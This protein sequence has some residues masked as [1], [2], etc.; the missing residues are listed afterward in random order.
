[1]E[2][3][4]KI[5]KWNLNFKS[6]PQPKKP[7]NKTKTKNK[8]QSREWKK[9]FE[10]DVTIKGLISK[11]IKN[12]S[13]SSLS[14]KKNKKKSNNPIQ[15]WAEDLNRHLSKGEIQMTN[16]CRKRCWISLIIREMQIK[17]TM[18][19]HITPVKMVIIKRQQIIRVGSN[20]VKRELLC[21]FGG[22]VNWCSP[23][24]KTLWRFLKKLKTKL[25]ND[26]A[27]PLLGIY[28]KIAKTLISKDICTPCPPQHHLQCPRYRCI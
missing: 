21:P 9:I 26:P 3:K 11:S 12:C 25:P 19:Y 10:N 4:I 5:S 13:Y 23:L 15:K 14:K 17:T 28:S 24:R 18:R 1:M 20:V 8:R 2:I 22:N 7:K 27:I 16:R 6:F